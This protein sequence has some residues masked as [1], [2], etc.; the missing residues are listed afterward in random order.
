MFVRRISAILLILI[1]VIFA[2]RMFQIYSLHGIRPY[3]LVST[4]GFSLP[5][6]VIGVL[7]LVLPLRVWRT[8]RLP[9]AF[10]VTGMLI[11]SF[12]AYMLWIFPS[13]A[14]RSSAIGESMELL[15]LDT[16]V[17]FCFWPLWGYGL[18]AALW[19][20]WRSRR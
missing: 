12:Q 2:Y 7:I 5:L 20:I 3:L 17:V 11:V 19:T 13:S 6:A 4:L 14:T 8:N 9:V 16:L 18:I 10:V 15:F 1:S